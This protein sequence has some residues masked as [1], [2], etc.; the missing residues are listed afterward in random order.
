MSGAWRASRLQTSPSS[1]AV[2]NR[3]KTRALSTKLIPREP[4][5]IVLDSA[6]VCLVRWKAESKVTCRMSRNGR[7]PNSSLLIVDLRI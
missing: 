3:L 7:D 6:P 5:S 4:R 2:G 1:T